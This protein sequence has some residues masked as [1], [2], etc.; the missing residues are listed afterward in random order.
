MTSIHTLA[1]LDDSRFDH[2]ALA[3]AAGK[4]GVVGTILNFYDAE[5]ALACLQRRNAPRIDVFLIDLHMPR[6]DGLKFIEA[7]RARFGEEFARRVL[8]ALTLD[9]DPETLAHIQASG[10]IDG[11]ISKPI[12][13][14]QIL[15]ICEGLK[16]LGPR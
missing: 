12:N 1:Y 3:R 14:E 16:E 6:M 5:D 4:T 13:P 8:L 9:P 11:W 10:G 15:K 7:A 2:K